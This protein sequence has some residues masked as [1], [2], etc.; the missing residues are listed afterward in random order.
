MHDTA[1]FFSVVIPTYNS[2]NFLKLALQSVLVQTD[3]DF[4]V[5]VIDNTSQDGTKEFIGNI[6]DERVR[7]F[8]VINDGVIG[9]SRN[10]GIEN[11]TGEWVCFLDA[12]DLWYPEKLAH[13]RD[14]SK[15]EKNAILVGHNEYIVYEN[16]IKKLRKSQPSCLNV[17]ESLLRYGSCLM[18]SAVSIRRDVALRLGGFSE[19]RE[20][21]TAEDYE[22]WIRLSREGV[23]Y[24]LDEIL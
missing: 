13:V 17:E 20:F 22:F 12:D 10:V 23:F 2:L 19:H 16:G 9:F 3:K 15:K 5:L 24:F 4:E 6:I 11:A 7:Y 21:V 14:V 8:E 1:P 18:T